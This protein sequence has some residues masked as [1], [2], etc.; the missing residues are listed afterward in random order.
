M[1]EEKFVRIII[2]LF[3][4]WFQ[5][6]EIKIFP[7]F[8]FPLFLQL[9]SDFCDLIT[10]SK[11]RFDPLCKSLLDKTIEELIDVLIDYVKPET[12][13]VGIKVCKRNEFFKN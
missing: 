1:N 13:C 2:L 9:I 7:F 11:P 6:T 4:N 5:A 3:E 12:I 10:A 8:Y